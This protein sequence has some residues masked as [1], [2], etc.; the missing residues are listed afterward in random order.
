MKISKIVSA[1]ALYSV[2]IAALPTNYKYTPKCGDKP[3]INLLSKR[4]S[5]IS[6][7]AGASTVYQ[8]SKCYGY[9]SKNQY[10]V[11]HHQSSCNGNI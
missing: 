7:S 4:S 5:E 10:D 11:A 1:A 6:G 8:C 9:I 3:G 2:G